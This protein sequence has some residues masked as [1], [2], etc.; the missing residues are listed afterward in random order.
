MKASV[1]VT[2]R[3]PETGIDLLRRNFEVDVFSGEG[4]IDRE[5]LLER[6]ADCDALIS[7]LSDRIDE[8]VLAAGKKLKIVANYAVGYN[9]IDVD[10]ARRRNIL[11]TNTPGVLTNATGEIAFALLIALTRNIIAADRFTREG[12][13]I[14]WAPLLFLGDELKGKTIGIL[15]MGR[16][17]LDMAAKCRAFGMHIIYY[18]RKPVSRE[19]ESSVGAVYCSLEE[20]LTQSDVI[21]IHTPLTEET[22]HLIDSN[23]F[24]KMKSGVYLINTSRG[25]VVDE[26]A[27]A[28]S[29]KSGRVKGAGLDVYEHEPEIHPELLGQPNVV[30]L[31]HIGS[32][33]IETREK[34][35][36]MAAR[37]V[38]AA[39]AGKRPET[40][41]PEMADQT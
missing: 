19:A 2:R 16:I 3:I 1:F 31:P 30:L 4:A 6:V 8:E 20:L 15:G 38:I 5:T 39:L 7:L 9:N 27:L 26:A 23:S 36:E 14:G 37:N 40:L 18:N 21:S 41:V 17:G 29:L 25:E 32:A 22:L 28:A 35:S 12:K 10:A 34:M 13:F 24:K 33:T 11:V